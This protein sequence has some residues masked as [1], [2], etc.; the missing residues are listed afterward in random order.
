MSTKVED[1][2]TDSA[3]G[4]RSLLR[5]AAV[6]VGL[7]IAV[8]FTLGLDRSLGSGGSDEGPGSVGRSGSGIG[9]SYIRTN[10]EEVPAE[11]RPLL[12]TIERL[13]GES[14]PADA[15]E[16]RRHDRAENPLEGIAE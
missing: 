7:A 5:A 15:T 14:A 8:G 9:E 13:D 10:P 12:G 3:D 1:R 4:P 16:V 6:V 11:L 2:R